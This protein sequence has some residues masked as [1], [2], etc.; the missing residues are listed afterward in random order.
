M[1]CLRPHRQ[2]GR[3]A[4]SELAALVL[5]SGFGSRPPDADAIKEGRELAEFVWSVLGEKTS[6]EGLRPRALLMLAEGKPEE[7][8]SFASDLQQLV[9]GRIGRSATEADK[10]SPS[11]YEQKGEAVTDDAEVIW[12]AYHFLAQTFL[13]A[14]CEKA[15]SARKTEMLSKYAVEGAVFKDDLQRRHPIIGPAQCGASWRRAA[16]TSARINRRRRQCDRA[17]ARPRRECDAQCLG[18]PLC[19]G[20]PAQFE[21]LPGVHH[22]KALQLGRLRDVCG[23]QARWKGLFGRG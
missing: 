5:E 22:G 15:C 19:D 17:E 10:K 4:Q 23:R 13:A 7:A 16:S 12:E 18:L 6:V 9:D 11:K 3:N 21:R 8:I 2:G 14:T 20:P 1:R